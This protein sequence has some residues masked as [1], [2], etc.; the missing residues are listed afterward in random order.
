MP[1]ELQRMPHKYT[2]LLFSSS[3]FLSLFFS[4]SSWA[5]S[6][7][8]SCRKRAFCDSTEDIWILLARSSSVAARSLSTAAA[9]K[10]CDSPDYERKVITHKPGNDWTPGWFW[11]QTSNDSNLQT[12]TGLSTEISKPTLVNA[13]GNIFTSECNRIVN[14]QTALEQPI[15]HRKGTKYPTWKLTQNGWQTPKKIFKI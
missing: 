10:V 2:H 8:F 12:K 6:L 15:T 5:W 13:Q 7:L 1:W 4:D 11:L 3:S 9:N 14:Q